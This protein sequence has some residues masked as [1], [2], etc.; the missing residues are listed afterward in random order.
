M[1]VL[2]GPSEEVISRL[3]ETLREQE[4]KRRRILQKLFGSFRENPKRQCIKVS[5]L[6][7]ERL[8]VAGIDGGMAQFSL[9]GL[10]IVLLKSLAAVFH[11]ARGK[12]QDAFYFPS[13]FPPL[14]ILSIQEPIDFW[15]F[16]ILAGMERQIIETIVPGYGRIIKKK[17]EELGLKQEDFARK[18]NEKVSLIHNIESEHF[19]PSINLARKIERFLK[20]KLVE[21]FEEQLSGKSKKLTSTD[22]M[23]IGDIIKI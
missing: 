4:E 22:E 13:E 11:Y 5:R 20:I 21:Q 6:T 23:T 3:V 9:K 14:N 1:L 8:R 2:Q 10:D 7:P 15:K 19:E 16:E 17:R 18:I 12:L